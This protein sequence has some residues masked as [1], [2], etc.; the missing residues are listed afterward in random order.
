MRQVDSNSAYELSQQ[1]N[2][3]GWK[4]KRTKKQI[5]QKKRQRKPDVSTLSNQPGQKWRFP[6][7]GKVAMCFKSF[8]HVSDKA[9]HHQHYLPI[10]VWPTT[11][12]F[13]PSHVNGLTLDPNWALLQRGCLV[14]RQKCL[15]SGCETWARP[16]G[17]FSLGGESKTDQHKQ[18]E[19]QFWPR[20]KGVMPLW[21]TH[22]TGSPVCL[23]PV[24]LDPIPDRSWEKLTPLHQ[25]HPHSSLSTNWVNGDR[26]VFPHKRL[27]LTGQSCVN[28]YL[29]LDNLLIVIMTRMGNTPNPWVF[30]CGC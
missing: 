29:I 2:Q 15:N 8:H 3:D 13:H 16:Q 19:F 30:D 21:Q 20:P 25:T 10:L 11:R 28:T 23:A 9:C 7:G 18:Q 6:S 17:H 22:Q 4:E 24:G 5:R 12:T 26:F 1:I 14:S 27:T